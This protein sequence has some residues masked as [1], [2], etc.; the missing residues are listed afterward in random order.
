MEYASPRSMIS[1]IDPE[2]HLAKLL[3]EAAPRII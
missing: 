2:K 1:L 3:R